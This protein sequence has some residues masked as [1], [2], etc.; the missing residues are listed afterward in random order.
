MIRR[1]L[2]WFGWHHWHSRPEFAGRRWCLRCD[3]NQKREHIM[4][5]PYQTGWGSWED[6]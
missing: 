3:A 2:C 4:Y 6:Q 5:G 1:I